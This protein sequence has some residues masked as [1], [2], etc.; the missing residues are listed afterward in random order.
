MT[1][2]NNVHIGSAATGNTINIS[3]HQ[4]REEKRHVEYSPIANSIERVSQATVK[5]GALAFFAS[6][7]LP[8]LGIVADTLGILSYVGVQAR[9]GRYS[10]LLYPPLLSVLL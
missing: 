7:S 2:D 4:G 6:L 8:I 1:H 5:R 9:F 3:Q 10:P